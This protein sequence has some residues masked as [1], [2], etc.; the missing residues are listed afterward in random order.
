MPTLPHRFTPSEDGSTAALLAVERADAERQINIIRAIVL[1]LLGVSAV[2]YAP[3]LPHALTLVNVS[4][5]MPMLLW[6]LCQEIRVHRHR[7]AGPWLTTVNAVVDATAVTALLAGYGMAGMPDLVVKSPIWVA[8]F[9]ILSARPFSSSAR[10]AALASTIVVAEYG[11][12]VACFIAIGHLPLHADPVAASVGRGTSVLD[13]GAKLLLLGMAGWVATYA[14]SWNERTLRRAQ[15]ALRASEAEMRA[16]V[17]AMSDVIVALDRDG[18]YVKIAASAADARHRP[19]VEW[20]GRRVT[21]VFP[22]APADTILAGVA[23]ALETRRA[24]DLEYSL[25]IGDTTAWFAGTVSPMDD[26]RVVWVARDIT[27][28]KNLE[29]QLAYQA[30]HDPLTGLANRALFRDRVDHALA[31]MERAGG[32]LAVLFLDLDDFKTVNDSL[33]HNEGDRLLAAV[34]ARFLNATRGC[35]TVAR[36]GG[37]EFAVLLE[38]VHTDSDVITVAERIAT[39][40]RAPFVLDEKP[41]AV[42]ASMGIARAGDAEGTEELLRNADVAMYTAKSAGKGRYA[43]FAPQMHRALVDRMALEADL[44]DGIERGELRLLYQPIVDLATGRLAAV[45]ALVRWEHPTRGLLAPAVFIPLAEET[46]LIVPLGRWVIRE[47]CKQGALW[48][49]QSPLDESPTVTVNLSGRQFQHEALV[50]DIAAALAESGLEPVRLVLEITESVIMRDVEVTLAR[51]LELKALGVRLAIDDFG[52]GYSSLSSLRRFP[53]D[54]LKIDKAFVDNI[55][56]G[57]NDAALARTIIALGDMLSLRTVAEGIEDAQQHRTL[58]ELG[59]ELGQGYLFAKPLPSD[60]IATMLALRGS[61][62]V[63]GG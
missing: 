52:T 19:P 14:T 42:T 40:L 35:D 60:Q 10:R 44:R 36:L 12:L 49:S 1:M 2:A 62:A 5:L 26:E 48:R 53:I 63:A 20:L 3:R 57:G 58:Q 37:D 22:P 6:T 18:A 51:L 25:E 45:E 47:A 4:V 27:S 43:I 46:G 29:A 39:S 21:E 50:S 15:S 7:R 16:L 41:V 55:T 38:S 59:C 23:R 54:V 9:V 28:R 33:G 61:T 34:A 24:V 17:G 11:V 13:E 30:L 32:R 31:G 8:Y 56:L